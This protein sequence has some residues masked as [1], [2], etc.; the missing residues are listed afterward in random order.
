MSCYFK[1]E[2]F[3]QNAPR[4]KRLEVALTAKWLS[5]EAAEALAT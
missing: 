2:R 4:R 3:E 1:Q 5:A